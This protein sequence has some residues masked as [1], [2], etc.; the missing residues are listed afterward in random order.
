MPDSPTRLTWSSGGA[1]RLP[2]APVELAAFE[3]YVRRDMLTVNER[4]RAGRGTWTE[5]VE[6]LERH[7]SS[8][9]AARLRGP[10]TV[11][12]HVLLNFATRS[13]VRWGLRQSGLPSHEVVA[14]VP[15][16]VPLLTELNR[17]RGIPE[18]DQCFQ[19]HAIDNAWLYWHGFTGAVITN[20]HLLDEQLFI[21]T[22]AGCSAYA[23]SARA[24]P[25]AS[26]VI[27]T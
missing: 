24:A 15:S 6:P 9:R 2:A 19:T 21:G 25:R 23:K 11:L 5:F 16:L 26:V 22:L 14:A 10:E 17:R 8:L 3:R 20:T 12:A 7:M 4:N 27:D 13:M 18:R 1:T